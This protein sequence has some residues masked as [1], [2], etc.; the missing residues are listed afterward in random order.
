[1]LGIHDFVFRI[2]LKWNPDV[3]DFYTERRMRNENY[4]EVGVS[5]DGDSR[6]EEGRR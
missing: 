4:D 2:H 6:Q 3:L 1:M 5:F